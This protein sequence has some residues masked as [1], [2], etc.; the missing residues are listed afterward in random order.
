MNGMRALGMLALVLAASCNGCDEIIES[1]T[2]QG[3]LDP[4][5]FNFGVVKV[6]A[7][8]TA[9]LK[10][11]NKGQ[12]DLQV[13]GHEIKDD[14]TGGAFTVGAIPSLVETGGEAEVVV[15]YAPTQAS[16]GMQSAT[17]HVITNDPDRSGRVSGQLSGEASTT[18][19]GKIL[20]RCKASVEDAQEG[21]LCTT[22]DVGG[23]PV[24]GTGMIGTISVF[25]DGTASFNILGVNVLP[26]EGAASTEFSLESVNNRPPAY[27]IEV[28]PMRGGDCG[29]PLTGDIPSVPVKILFKPT[30]GGVQTARVQIL[31]DAPTL[32]TPAGV[33][34]GQGHINVTG[35]GSQVGLSLEPAFVAFGSVSVGSSE[36]KT[37]RVANLNNRQAPVN[38]TCIDMNNNGSCYQ[39]PTCTSGCA[40]DPEDVECTGGDADPTTGL[41]CDVDGAGKGFLLEATDAQAGGLDEKEVR[42][43]WTPPAAASFNKRLLF[44][45]GIGNF[46]VYS[47]QLTGGVA[48]RIAVDPASFYVPASA[49]TVGATGSATFQVRNEGEAPLVISRI[50]FVGSSSIADDFTL[51]RQE[52]SGFTMGCTR[53]PNELSCPVPAWTSSISIEAGQSTTFLVDYADNDEAVARDELTLALTHNGTGG[54]PFNVELTVCKPA[55][56][57]SSRPECP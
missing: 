16:N 47:V 51:R 29:E 32:G 49:D 9:K 36:T 14:N 22:M 2:A 42:V 27:P 8:C 26:A 48:G 15:Q 53:D 28:K 43:T 37:I 33:P 5:V 34:N 45:T 6:G 20:P 40:G 19:A 41:N 12:Q 52:D 21:P 44:M 35:L 13:S 39:D 31:T 56:G 57:G 38:S 24:G 55:G 17:I 3:E 54:N 50:E 7:T 1:V 30:R 10:L 23:T 11:R 46:N 4:A 25:N 18:L